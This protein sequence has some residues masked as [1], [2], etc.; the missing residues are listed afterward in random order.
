[1]TLAE[2]QDYTEHA[3]GLKDAVLGSICFYSVSQTSIPYAEAKARL[4]AVGLG[5]ALPRSAP[6]DIDVFR[7]VFSN[8]QRR[9]RVIGP[10]ERENLLI[11]EVSR[12]PERLVRRIVVETVDSA[13]ELL[14]YDEAVEVEFITAQ[15]SRLNIFELQRDDEM[16]A[17]VPVSDLNPEPEPE[18]PVVAELRAIM[19]EMSGKPVEAPEPEA[20]PERME[21]FVTPEGGFKNPEAVRLASELNIAYQNERGCLDGM[22]VRGLI[23]RSLDACKATLVKESGGVYFVSSAYDEQLEALERLAQSLPGVDL[24]TLPLVDDRKQRDLV[25]K[26]FTDEVTTDV[27]RAILECTE[28]LKSGESVSP[29]KFNALNLQYKRMKE[30]AEEYT[31]LLEEQADTTQFGLTILQAKLRQVLGKVGES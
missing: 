7:R 23:V 8:G 3:R 21:K 15:P 17:T 24:H 30:K 4:D 10:N 2:I 16:D 1:M 26:A 14:S 29:R 12:S 9:T 25:K 22:G 19:A 13:G 5:A 27:Q 11:R 6:A 20:E 28:A 31:A 18:N